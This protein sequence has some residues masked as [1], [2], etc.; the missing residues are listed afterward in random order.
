MLINNTQEAITLLK[1]AVDC[2]E[3]ADALEK[4]Q[5]IDALEYMEEQISMLEGEMEY[6]SGGLK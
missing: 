1:K 5:V 4:N 2:Y 6:I 3:A